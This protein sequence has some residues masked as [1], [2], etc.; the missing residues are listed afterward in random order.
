MVPGALFVAMPGSRSDGHDHV[1]EAVAAGAAAVLAERPTGVAV[2]EVVVPSAQAVIGALAAD[3]YGHPS[4]RM[5]V[6]GVTGTNG[7]TTVA[8]TLRQTLD[9]TGLPSGQ[10]G[11]VGTYFDGRVEHPNLTTPQ[12]P[13]L[14]EILYQMVQAGVRTVALEVSSHGLV[15]HRID[16]TSMQLGIFTN[17]SREHLDY[18]GTM[19][20]YFEAKARLFQPDRCRSAIVCVDDDWGRRLAAE[21]EIP[22]LTF[23]RTP[24]ADVRYTVYENG[25]SGI[26][27]DLDG[28]D[29]GVRIQARLI[30]HLNGPNVAAAYLAA[31]KLGVPSA[32]AVAAIG[33]SA[34][35]PG[36][37]EV[38]DDGQP[39]LVVVDYAHTPE[40]LAGMIGTARDLTG[41]AGRITVVAGAR[42]GRDRGKRPEIGRAAASA[43]GVI[44]TTDSPGD[45]DPS[46]I[47][48]DLLEG[49]AAT[50]S[51]A[52]ICVEL[53]RRRAINQAIVRSS[54]GDVVL[55]VGRGH[56]VVQ[57][58]GTRTV[59]LDDREV[60]REAVAALDHCRKAG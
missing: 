5:A 54:P 26:T 2:P 10:I 22:T 32:A 60:A 46:A 57:H 40:S 12:A 18:H 51:Q 27:V 37:F 36:R 43:D 6:V 1:S 16:G 38:I 44:L 24:T 49:A 28:I 14:Q 45:E 9:A 17:L 13:D 39:F 56:E 55:V 33:A 42:G 11:T 4:D 59:P 48:D 58:V 31:R 20:H 25:L 29:G 52:E 3:F 41:S 19:E 47:V 34:P 7:K 53:D 35:P 8:S 23:G 50:A 15:Q 30:G 21:L